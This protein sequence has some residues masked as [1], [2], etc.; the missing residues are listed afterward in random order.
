VRRIIALY[1]NAVTTNALV[2]ILR[3]KQVND[4]LAW[5]HSVK[6]E[7]FANLV[8]MLHELQV[9]DAHDLRVRL[10]QEQFCIALQRLQGIGPKTVDYM[11]CLSGLES[12]AVDRHIRSYASKAG[13]EGTEYQFLKRVFCFAADLLSISRRGFDAWVW[14]RETSRSSQMTL[15]I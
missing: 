14:Q 3:H 9:S 7:R 1:P 4:F 13:V 2:E 15:A 8:L 5:D 11:A 10:Q 6:V 12:V